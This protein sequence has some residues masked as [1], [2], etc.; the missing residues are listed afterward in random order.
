ML[1][2][3]PHIGNAPAARI[4]GEFGLRQLLTLD[5]STPNRSPANAGFGLNAFWTKIKRAIGSCR[6][7]RPY[8]HA[9]SNGRPAARACRPQ[10]HTVAQR[11]FGRKFRDKGTTYRSQALPPRQSQRQETW[12][13]SRHH[14]HTMDINAT[15]A[16]H[17]TGPP[18]HRYPPS[19][20]PRQSQALLC[21]FVSAS[22][23]APPGAPAHPDTP[24]CR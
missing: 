10:Q 15:G 7:A 20:P 1:W 23:A 4:Y 6:R 18:R 8:A 2:L 12:C 21:P 24:G 17:S 11:G 13:T 5:E 19:W 22:P 3:L 14:T 9:S 16:Q